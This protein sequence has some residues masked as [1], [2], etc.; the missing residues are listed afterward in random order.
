MAYARLYLARVVE[1]KKPSPP[2]D[3]EPMVTIRSGRTLRLILQNI[4]KLFKNY[5][6][7]PENLHIGPCIKFYIYN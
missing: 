3:P 2:F 5:I 7:V 4:P 6:L 1:L